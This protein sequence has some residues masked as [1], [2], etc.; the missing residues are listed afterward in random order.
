MKCSFYLDRP[1]N[2][3]IP[4]DIIKRE[5]VLAKE[6]KRPLATKYYNPRPTSVYVFFSPDKSIR[7]KYRTS[8]KIQPKYW[9]FKDGKVKSTAPA[10]ILLNGELSK[11][12]ADIIKTA[13]DAKEKAAIISINDYKRI[14]V[15]CVDKDN[16][17][18]EPNQLHR[19]IEDFKTYKAFHSATGT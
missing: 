2:P 3:E 10:S 17:G 7:I 14:I 9:D 13:H 1:Y 4:S 18:Y 12:S 16:I 6:K 11:L 8:I 19:L 15:E 5:V